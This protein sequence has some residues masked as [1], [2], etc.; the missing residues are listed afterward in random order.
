MTE[1]D[2]KNNPQTGGEWDSVAPAWEKNHDALA[3]GLE[4]CNDTMLE[5]A[6]IAPGLSVLDLGS[7]T[8][9]PALLAAKEVG[10]TGH[11]TGVDFSG[12]MLDA[13]RRKAEALGLGNIKFK[14]CDVT[15]LPFEDSS[16]DAVTSRFCLMFLPDLAK[17]LSEV[18]RVLKPGGRFSAAVWADVNRNPYISDP[19][20]I[21]REYV[22][23][24]PPDRSKPGIFSLAEPGALREKMRLAKF[25]ELSEKE[26]PVYRTASSG[27]ECVNILKE[28]A[29]P[30]K[31]MFAALTPVQ[32]REAEDKMVASAEKYRK[33]DQIEIPGAVLV[34]SG[35]KPLAVAG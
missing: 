8:G 31:K 13:A 1:S 5:Q 19:M 2:V 15:D 16:F 24:P 7:G 12:E 25:A 23:M 33:G 30:M 29:A 32:G 11:V 9:Y 6:G 17:T 28:M 14:E 3:E 27:I 21:L 35:V 26:I 22:E 20:K 34:L 18:F 10:P 4:T